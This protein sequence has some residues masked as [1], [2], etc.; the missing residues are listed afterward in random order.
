[1]NQHLSSASLKSLAKGQLLGK[2]G[3]VIGAM[4]L[5]QLCTLPIS[6]SISFL[7]GTN[8]IAGVLLYS[9]AQFLLQLFIGFFLAGEAYIYLKIAC[10]QRPEIN[11]LF[12]CFKGDAAKI[13]KLQ[14][15]L[16]GVSI[17]SS[18]P[19]LIIETIVLQSLSLLNTEAILTG[20]F[21]VNPTL[22]LLYVIFY[23]IGN[24]VTIYIGLMLSQVFY[25]MLDFPEYSASQL[26]K[27]S[28]RLMNGNK[29]RLFYIQISFIPLILLCL[30]SCGIALLWVY[31]YMKATYANFYLDLIR[32]KDL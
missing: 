17:L 23:L 27:M 29:G 25:M 20:N 2:Y 31:P 32:K 30:L 12:H 22:F 10:G 5:M 11:D 21:P 16:S 4:I 14:A 13:V 24:I 28:I 26:F 19:A 15:V 6:A 1:M 3:T 7:V 8:T 18:L 9:A